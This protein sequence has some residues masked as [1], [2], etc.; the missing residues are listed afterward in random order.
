M[1]LRHFLERGQHLRG[2]EP[3]Q[4][5]DVVSGGRRAIVAFEKF[6]NIDVVAERIVIESSAR[7]T[8]R[9]LEAVIIFSTRV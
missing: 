9:A 2:K 1:D 3:F 5:T 4:T 8:L 6:G 7:Q